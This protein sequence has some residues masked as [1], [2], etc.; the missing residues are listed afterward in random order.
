MGDEATYAMQAES[1]AFDADLRYTADDFHRLQEHWG[2]LPQGLILQSGDDGATIT[3]GKPVFYPLYLAPFLWLSPIRGPLLANVLI[4]A[5][6]ALASARVLEVRLG[7][8]APLWIAALV[9]GSVSFGFVFWVHADLFLMALCALGYALVFDDA[10]RLPIR[11]PWRWGLAGLLLAV[12]A[13]SRPTYAPLFLPALAMV[14]WRDRRAVVALLGAAAALVLASAS[15]HYALTST[16]TGYGALRSG[17][18]AHTGYP[19]IDFS[20]DEW[21]MRVKEQGN[22]AARGPLGVLRDKR[23][24]PSL[25]GWNSLYFVFGRHVGLVPYFLPGLLCLLGPWRERRWWVLLLAAALSVGLFLWTRPFNFYGGG[26]TLANRYFLPI[27]PALWFALG[28]RLRLSWVAASIALA[29]VFL[30]P[31]WGSAATYPLG[32][33]GAYRYVS[34]VAS[35]LLPFETTQSHLRLAGRDDLYEDGYYL[36]LVDPELRQ[37]GDGYLRI[38]REV[39]GTVVVGSQSPLEHLDLL[40]RWPGD[41][42]PWVDGISIEDLG[43][44]DLGGEGSGSA[45]EVVRH[46][47][48]ELG[49]ADARHP[50]WWTWEPAHL[51][52]LDLRFEG[53]SPPVPGTDPRVVFRLDRQRDDPVAE[54]GTPTP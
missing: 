24:T 18:Y 5:L 52:H 30:F 38:P 44:V 3:Y 37:G 6:A 1:L 40:L 8:W 46:Y 51:Y 48:L 12:V 33:D 10:G 20:T 2:H 19:E 39:E 26:G 16:W 7:P 13:F 47:R 45:G 23:I 49:T 17:F 42:I 53:G 9:F 4:L 41:A 50:L 43:L 32:K 11:G 21:V 29:G 54:P 27:Y 36:R 14:P 25:V 34:P 31:L 35:E 15:M 28:A 22:A